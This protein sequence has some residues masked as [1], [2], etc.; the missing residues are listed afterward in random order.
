[1]KLDMG[2]RERNEDVTIREEKVLL[3]CISI[4]YFSSFRHCGPQMWQCIYLDHERELFHG[5]R[6]SA[7]LCESVVCRFTGCS[8]KMFFFQIP[9]PVIASSD[10][11]SFQ[12]NTCCIQS[13]LLDCFLANYSGEVL[14]LVRG[15]KTLEIITIFLEHPANV[16]NGWHSAGLS[17]FM[18]N[19]TQYLRVKYALHSR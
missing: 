1:M 7:L 14:G 17:Q 6:L 13:L 10:P 16:L 12:R 11:K 8:R 2:E 4:P 18:P 5:A 15:G 9:H 3:L 19:L